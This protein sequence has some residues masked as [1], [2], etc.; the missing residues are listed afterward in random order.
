MRRIQ[1]PNLAPGDLFKGR[2]S[3]NNTPGTFIRRQWTNDL[4][5]EVC[6]FI[7]STGMLL[8][9]TFYVD[10][11]G[12][13]TQLQQAINDYVHRGNYYT[14]TGTADA[15][16]LTPSATMKAPPTLEHG[17]V[18]RFDAPNPNT[19]ASTLTIGVNTKPI[20]T[21]TGVDTPAGYLG[22]GETKARYDSVNEWFVADREIERGSNAN[23]K[24]K[25]FSDGRMDLL[26][27]GNN[28][29]VLAN[30]APATFTRTVP[31][32]MFDI[33]GAVSLA[34]SNLNGVLFLYAESATDVNTLTFRVWNAS[35]AS[36]TYIYDQDATVKTRWY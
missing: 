8:D 6:L 23:G 14:V 21:V 36:R 29:A 30:T 1:D 34:G 13:R 35:G 33:L 25:K 9:T 4:Q 10:G 3:G 11:T 7:E 18:Y 12:D 27:S 16:I 20:K 32:T 5:E 28:T 2:D 22:F 24:Y 26:V 19:G 17:Q 15:L 31:A